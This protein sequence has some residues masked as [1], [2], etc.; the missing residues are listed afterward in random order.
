MSQ[1]NIAE[2]IADNSTASNKIEEYDEK[3]KEIND[4]SNSSVDLDGS[5]KCSDIDYL[6]DSDVVLSK[7]INIINDAIDE[8]GFTWYHAKLFCLAGFGYSADSQISM[9]QS[10]VQTYIN[11]QYGR[12]YPISVELCYAG[13]FAG[14]IFW[15]ATADL[16]G[17]K[18]AFNTS[19][20]LAAIFGF[21]AGGSSSYGMYGVFV[22]LA[23]FSLGGNLALDV[24][25]FLEFVP[26]KY[27]W[28]NTLMASWW[29]VGQTIMELT[30]WA[31]IPNFSCS[32]PEN[33][34]MSENR[35]WR[36][37]WYLNSGI[38]LVAACLRMFVF[39]LNETP[40][41]LVSNKRDAEAVEVLQ[42]IAKQYNRSCSLTLEEL[43]DCGEIITNE[44]FMKKGGSSWGAAYR[45]VKHHF[46]LLYANKTVGRSTSLLL[47]SWF[48]IGITYGIYNNF[49][50]AF[51]ASRNVDTGSTP[52]QIYRDATLECF[53][54][55][56]G[57]PI[58]VGLMFIPKVG[59]RGAMAIG[60]IIAMAFLFGY[61]KVTNE[62]G[63][64]FMSSLC[65]IFIN[66]Y[67]G[68]LYAYTPEVLASAN[69]AT[70]ASLAL[71]M[72]RIAGMLVPVI[73][74]YSNTASAAPIYVCGA[75]I[76]AIA[77]SALLF[78]F[79]PSRRRSV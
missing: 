70:G 51:L 68:T 1:H 55:I 26:H 12:S 53:F 24:S 65:Y 73:A 16:I 71:A 23:N 50:Y 10:A 14:A 41:F 28:M 9:V 39:Q 44:D 17:R 43:E 18:I 30:A 22:F 31:F 34:V 15:G 76:G 77:L 54:S 66:I 5:T 78:P 57:P 35:G 11:Y 20:F 36:Y 32:G 46:G 42:G 62:I 58:A 33:C 38:V 25:V 49:L 29:A 19:L 13:L 52:Y 2:D 64:V 61:T 74:Y 4:Y 6:Q 47:F 37:T 79:E 72:N 48:G 56:F 63:N 3:N 40:K 27:Q 59:R 75:L 60:G 21:F 45:Q 7:K 69:R 8:I 67:Y